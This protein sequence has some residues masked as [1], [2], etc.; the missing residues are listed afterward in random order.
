MWKREALL[1]Q[2]RTGQRGPAI[3]GRQHGRA[4]LL[5]VFYAIASAVEID[6]GSASLF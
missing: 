2:Q 3:R 1:H 4:V 5:H 6:R